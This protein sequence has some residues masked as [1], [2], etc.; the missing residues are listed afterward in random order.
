MKYLTDHVMVAQLMRNEENLN[1][2]MAIQRNEVWKDARRS[3]FM[4]SVIIGFP[5]NPIHAIL[6]EGEAMDVLDGKQRLTTILRYVADQFKLDA[7]TPDAIVNGNRYEIKGLFYSQLPDVLKDKIKEYKLFFF[8]Y[9][10]IT[11]DEIEELFIRLNNGESLT[12]VE[13]TRVMAGTEVMNFVQEVGEYYFMKHSSN[14]TDNQRNRF[15]DEEVILSAMM[16]EY[17]EDYSKM[18]TGF[19]GD[20]IRAFAV[21]LNEKG[22]DAE[23]NNRIRQVFKFMGD[24]FPDQY[25]MLRKAQIPSIYIMASRCLD[26]GWT[27]KQFGGMV[28]YFFYKIKKK[29]T[30]A[31]S[32]KYSHYTETTGSGTA[33]KDKVTK[34]IKIVLKWVEEVLARGGATF[35]YQEPKKGITPTGLAAA[36]SPV[37]NDK[38]EEPKAEEP[39]AENSEVRPEP[40]WKEGEDGKPIDVEPQTTVQTEVAVTSTLDPAPVIE[41]KEE[42]EAGKQAEELNL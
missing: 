27:P 26:A 2:E 7:S 31:G 15:Q 32:Y 10:D 30:L 12:K 13:L 40:M 28:E 4:H 19:G 35:Q 42:D 3:L 39:K 34:R 16:L 25:S 36:S 17:A 41:A 20:D 21:N 1:F 37:N 18:T 5:T 24:S 11:D 29:E 33:K 14:L 6:G 9:T 23:K 22:M 38:A 8:T